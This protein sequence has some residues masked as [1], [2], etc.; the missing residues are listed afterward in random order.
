MSHPDQRSYGNEYLLRNV[1]EAELRLIMNVRWQRL[2]V[3]SIC[4]MEIVGGWL[5]R[6]DRTPD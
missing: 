2:F 6:V 5:I 4:G 3:V 1:S